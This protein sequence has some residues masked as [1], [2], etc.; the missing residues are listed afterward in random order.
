MGQATTLNNLK[1]RRRR[2]YWEFKDATENDWRK[3]FFEHELESLNKLIEYLEQ[4]GCI[5]KGSN[6]P[7]KTSVN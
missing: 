1:D 2:K 4:T 6:M 5:L 7:P 3:Q